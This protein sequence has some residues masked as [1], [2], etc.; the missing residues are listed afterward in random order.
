MF[1]KRLVEQN[2][3]D[4]SHVTEDEEVLINTQTG[5]VIGIVVDS[6]YYMKKP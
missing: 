3:E 6:I 1:L 5:E 4:L 2:I